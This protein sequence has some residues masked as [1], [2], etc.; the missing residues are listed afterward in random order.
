M[1]LSFSQKWPKTMP[2]HLAG[3]NTLFPLKILKSLEAE[4]PEEMHAFKMKTFF[5]Y[6]R[7]EGYEPNIFKTFVAKLHTI[8]A[9]KK[10][11]WFA[12]RDIHFVINNRTKN[13]YQFAPLIPCVDTQEIFF[14]KPLRGGR[15]EVSIGDT[16]LYYAD[17]TKL[18]KN[19]GFKCFE[20]F[21]AYFEPQIS[22]SGLSLE[23][24]HWTNFKY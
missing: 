23:L 15:I 9:D 18:A 24:I 8:R 17:L 6:G 19:D 13:R 21:E 12:G 4:Y 7:F 5:N 11:R 3:Q 2:K 22:D 1:T 16:Y 14:T 10:G 20:D